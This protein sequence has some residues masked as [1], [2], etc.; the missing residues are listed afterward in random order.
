MSNEGFLRRW[1]RLKAEPATGMPMTAPARLQPPARLQLAAQLEPPVQLEPG[2]PAPVTLEDA[3]G[4]GPDSDYS[5]FVV[6]GVDKAVQRLALKKLFA[7]PHFNIM[8]GL[9]I[10]ISDYNKA[11]PIPPAMLASLRQAQAFLAKVI[12]PDEDQ[13]PADATPASPP[14][15]QGS[16]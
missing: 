6:R 11:D 10:Y 9:D 13:T 3:A 2:A 5:A 14:S 12:E 16:A 4:L 8:D 15:Q 1:S 7:D